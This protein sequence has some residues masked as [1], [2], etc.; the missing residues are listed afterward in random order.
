MLRGV[1]QRNSLS[2]KPTSI[3][4]DS[5]GIGKDGSYQTRE[6]ETE[7]SVFKNA[8]SPLAC[9]FTGGSAFSFEDPAPLYLHVVLKDESGESLVLRVES[10]VRFKKVFEFCAE[11]KKVDVSALQFTLND[12]TVAPADSPLYLYMHDGDEIRVAKKAKQIQVRVRDH[13]GEQIVLQV[14]DTAHL[15][16]LFKLYANRKNVSVEKLRFLVDEAVVEP[17]ETPRLLNMSDGDQIDVILSD[18][19]IR[20]RD[21]GTGDQLVLQVCDMVA[22]EKVFHFYAKKHDL[23]A[24]TLRFKLYGRVIEPND[25]PCQL[26]MRGGDLV[27]IMPV[28]ILVRIRDIK[29]GS[30]MALRVKDTTVF[31]KVFERYIKERGLADDV[32]SLRFLLDDYRLQGSDTSLLLGLEDGQEICLER[33]ETETRRLVNSICL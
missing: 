23:D 30:I 24:R 12:E 16:C 1:K 8:I 14:D 10:T 32:A 33:T 3:S 13:T 25:T 19:R 18:I 17:T 28:K 11:R 15:G 4:W 5:S 31:A 9:C 2:T 21:Q 29:D 6:F 27:D 22:F 7:E 20:L 26:G